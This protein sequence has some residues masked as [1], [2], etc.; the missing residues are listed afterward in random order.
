MFFSIMFAFQYL[1]TSS[2]LISLL[3]NLQI[4]LKSDLDCQLCNC[5]SIDFT[6]I[7][8]LNQIT[9]YNIYKNITDNITNTYVYWTMCAHYR[10]PYNKKD[11]FE[12]TQWLCDEKLWASNAEVYDRYTQGQ[13]HGSFEGLSPTYYLQKFC[14]GVPTWHVWGSS[15]VACV[16]RPASNVQHIQNSN[17]RG[18]SCTIIFDVSHR[19]YLASEQLMSHNDACNPWLTI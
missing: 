13:E 4:W 6:R 19:S 2:N 3:K 15:S 8:R 7:S 1:F 11:Q 16:A 17:P 12:V 10:W 9:E 5:E 18:F 14:T